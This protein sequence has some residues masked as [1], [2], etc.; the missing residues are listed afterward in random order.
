MKR[1]TAIILGSVALLAVIAIYT[2]GNRRWWWKR[3][4]S[5]WSYMETYEDELGTGLRTVN[6][7][8][9]MTVPDLISAYFKGREGWERIDQD[10]A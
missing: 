6:V 8:E 1:K 10:K 7:P 9:K 4:N 2:V 3:V 5:R